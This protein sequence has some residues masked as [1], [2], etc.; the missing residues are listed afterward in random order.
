M[1]LAAD[2]VE[3][4]KVD[5]KTFYAR[6]YWHPSVLQMDSELQEPVQE[7]IPQEEEDEE[8]APLPDNLPTKVKQ[9]DD[10][11]VVSNPTSQNAGHLYKGISYPGLSF[12]CISFSAN[13]VSR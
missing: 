9:E 7:H 4:H 2:H 10:R 5:N 13:S 6:T 11:A 1:E 8:S 3:T 12:A